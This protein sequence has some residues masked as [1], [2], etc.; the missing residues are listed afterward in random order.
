MKA[1]TI[2]CEIDC[3]LIK[4]ICSRSPS[5]ICSD[6]N[7]PL[8]LL[9]K[10]TNI[11]FHFILFI[12][13]V[14]EFLWIVLFFFRRFCLCFI[15][16]WIETVTQIHLFMCKKIAWHWMIYIIY[17]TLMI[18]TV[19]SDDTKNNKLTEQMKKETRDKR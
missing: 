9:Y 12:Y 17:S 5:I 14:F 13:L 16:L 7:H 15:H 19:E 18:K 4:I 6:R 1:E 10:Q 3:C 11:Q 8:A 2:M